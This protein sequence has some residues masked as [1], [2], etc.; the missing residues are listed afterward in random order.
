[1]AP[2]EKKNKT[3]ATKVATSTFW[4]SHKRKIIIAIIATVIILVGIIIYIYR[5]DIIYIYRNNIISL[6]ASSL[7]SEEEQGVE[8]EEISDDVDLPQEPVA[9]MSDSSHDPIANTLSEQNTVSG[10]G[11]DLV[12]D[13]PEVG[14]PIVHS[15]DVDGIQ[16][17]QVPVNLTF[18]NLA[19]NYADIKASHAHYLTHGKHICVNNKSYKVMAVSATG[20]TARVNVSPYWPRNQTSAEF[21]LGDCPGNPWLPPTQMMATTNTNYMKVAAFHPFHKSN[22]Y[23]DNFVG[24]N[25]SDI[26][27]IS[28]GDKVCIN[29]VTFTVKRVNPNVSPSVGYIVLDELMRNRGIKIMVNDN[30]H[31]GEC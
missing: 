10:M 5:E 12:S 6:A 11:G 2:K 20:T 9:K 26:N 29:S 23:D 1:M 15:T 19:Q 31:V 4:T 18:M 24:V 3:V 30:V 14:E 21:T 25:K 16:T 22:G 27:R 17:E 28:V 7:P 8:F 13:T